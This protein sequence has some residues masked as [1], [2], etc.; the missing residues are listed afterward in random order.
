M[1]YGHGGEASRADRV[2]CGAGRTAV[3]TTRSPAPGANTRPS[4]VVAFRFTVAAMVAPTS[5]GAIEVVLRAS[6]AAIRRRSAAPP[7]V[8]IAEN[9]PPDRAADRPLG[10]PAGQVRPGPRAGVAVR[11]SPGQLVQLADEHDLDGGDEHGLRTHLQRDGDQRRRGEPLSGG[12]PADGRT[13]AAGEPGR[14][15][16]ERIGDLGVGR[17][18]VR[19][20]EPLPVPDGQP[21][22]RGVEQVAQQATGR[23]AA[24][25][26]ASRRPGRR[27]AALPGGSAADAR[28]RR[29]RR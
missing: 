3:R 4:C 2:V 25:G 7:T 13:D 16:D 17:A 20:A 19:P 6:R 24:G 8:L 12:E 22:C 23:P 14:P 21:G 10:G 1:G 27:G 9:S 29:R 28:P 15:G 11:A 18:G 26:R 5:S